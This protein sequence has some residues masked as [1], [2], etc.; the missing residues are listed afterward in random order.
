[1]SCLRGAPCGGDSGF[2]FLGPCWGSRPAELDP[3]VRE[4][5]EL[6]EELRLEGA[7]GKLGFRGGV[8]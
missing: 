4:G 2:C 3:E 5:V 1:M 6:I 8:R 7:A